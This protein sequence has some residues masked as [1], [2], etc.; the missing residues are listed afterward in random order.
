MPINANIS[1]ARTSIVA[2]NE[3]LGETEKRIEGIGK[4]LGDC[5]PLPKLSH[6]AH[7]NSALEHNLPYLETAIDCLEQLLAVEWSINGNDVLSSI[8]NIFVVL[9]EDVPND[10]SY[11]LEE[12]N[13]ISE[14]L[15]SDFFC[16]L[17]PDCDEMRQQKLAFSFGHIALQR[18]TA[19]YNA[20]KWANDHK[21][22]QEANEE[23]SIRNEQMNNSIEELNEVCEHR[24]EELAKLEERLEE[25]NI[26][27][28][29]LTELVKE[30]EAAR[31][32]DK[33]EYD[34]AM[35]DLNEQ[36][37]K[38]SSDCQ[39]LQQEKVSLS[40]Q[41]R[42]SDG[43]QKEL[44]EVLNKTDA[45]LRG[46]DLEM[47]KVKQECE[48]ALRRGRKK[49]GGFWGTVGAIAAGASSL[50]IALMTPNTDNN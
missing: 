48:A 27:R 16:Q 49:N 15:Y 41:I 14:M 23:M 42:L 28:I 22:L 46:M 38:I 39:T 34:R 12:L 31:E 17:I 47:K 2:I 20:I 8:N 5:L 26:D 10:A 3:L 11:K 44:T 35:E 1:V 50:L 33:L 43:K 36:M 24:A 13:T 18:V 32:K 4:E 25:L 29:K 6:V 30:T 9:N 37:G 21:K 7:E 19:I 45:E 40:E